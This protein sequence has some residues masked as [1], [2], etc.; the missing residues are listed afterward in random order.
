MYEN[1]I[2]RSNKLLLFVWSTLKKKERK[3]NNY[4]IFQSV[5]HMESASFPSE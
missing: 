5:S 4:V 1:I 3:K 2:I